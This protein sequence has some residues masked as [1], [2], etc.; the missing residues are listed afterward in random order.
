MVQCLEFDKKKTSMKY[1]KLAKEIVE[2]TMGDHTPIQN[3][4]YQEI[5][6]LTFKFPVLQKIN[7]RLHGIVTRVLDSQF[8]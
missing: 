4:N 3:G 5:N 1:F 7:Q 6:F 2:T 8:T